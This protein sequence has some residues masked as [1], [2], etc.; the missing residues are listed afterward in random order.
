MKGAGLC[1]RNGTKSES[2]VRS[3][4]F[5]LHRGAIQDRRR[6]DQSDRGAGN[7]GSVR[8]AVGLGEVVGFDGWSRSHRSTSARNT[9][10]LTAP[11]YGLAARPLRS[12]ST[13]VG[14]ASMA[15]AAGDARS[16]MSTGYGRW[17]SLK[18][19]S[20]ARFPPSS[21]ETPT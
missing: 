10:S 14:N 7:T 8:D 21:I 16:G 9:H 4:F 5:V 1:C 17:N 2:A 13:E 12:T 15:G 20:T 19:D 6:Q 18:N 11:I 3:A